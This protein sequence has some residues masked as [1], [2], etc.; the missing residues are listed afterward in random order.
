M[1]LVVV[2]VALFAGACGNGD[3]RTPRQIVMASAATTTEAKTSKVS[4]NV[5]MSKSST[6][7]VTTMTMEGAFDYA[8]K[9]GRMTME[10]PFG[11]GGSPQRMETLFFGTVL[12]EQLPPQLRPMLGGKPWVKIDLQAFAKASGRDFG[13]LSTLQSADPTRALAQLRG[14]SD[15]VTEVGREQVRGEDTTHYRFTMDLEK[16]IA[17]APEAQRDLLRKSLEKAATTNVPAEAWIDGD[18]RLRK[19][20]QAI[21]TTTTGPMTVTIE[22]FDFGTDVDVREPPAD[23]VADAMQFLPPAQGTTPE[24]Q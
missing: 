19:L 21:T 7:G 12:Y 15:D 3:D 8:N 13:D 18:G 14:V 16:A 4:I 17:T 9:Q 11:E 22:L 1:G 6:P 2:V 24:Q 20:V 10:L 23:D 5:D